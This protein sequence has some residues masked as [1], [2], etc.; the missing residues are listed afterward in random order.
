MPSGRR[1][2][3][4]AFLSHSHKDREFVSQIAA[5]LRKNRIRFW[6]SGK[7]IV[8]AEQWH[9]EIGK[10]LARCDW[11]ILFISP[12]A[13]RS[14]WVKQE[15]LYSLN[16]ARYE[17]RIVPVIVKDCDFGL[18][19]WTLHQIEMVDF[20]KDF[21]AGCRALLRIWGLQPPADVRPTKKR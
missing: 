9:D 19:S 14:R 11:F 15:L 3:V 21:H 18:L 1:P 16:E 10:A 6:Y 7:H 20:R 17:E 2:P 5:L 8:G 13:V 12:N 4:E